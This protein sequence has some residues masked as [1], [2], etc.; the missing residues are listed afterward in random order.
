MS[1]Q[2]SP[3]PETEQSPARDGAD[4]DTSRVPERSKKRRILRL[5][6][7]SVGAILAVVLVIVACVVVPIATHKNVGPATSSTQSP[8]SPHR[9]E[10]T[11]ADDRVRSLVAVLPD[12]STAAPVLSV[13]AGD[14]LIV[15]GSGFDTSVGVYLAICKDSGDPA[16][17]P[18]PCLG[19]I[20]EDAQQEKVPAGGEHP[21]IC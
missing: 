4:T 12:G 2:H 5:V 10:T 7:W 19:G 14:Q 17:K 11:A 16:Q 21:P 18:G 6:L 9:I 15:R 1:T 20:P 3:T 13:H 8:D